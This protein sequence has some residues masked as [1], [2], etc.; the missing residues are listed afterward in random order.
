MG[1]GYLQ[2]K[3]FFTLDI[4]LYMGNGYLHRKNQP[5]RK[6]FFTWEMFIYIRT[7]C[8]PVILKESVS[9][10]I[11]CTNSRCKGIFRIPLSPKDSIIYMGNYYLHRKHI[12]SSH[13]GQWP[14]LLTLAFKKKNTFQSS[15]TMAHS[16]HAGISNSVQS[17]Q[18][19]NISK[20]MVLVHLLRRVICRE[21]F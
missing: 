15:W 21:C 3:S 8:L 17:A 20:V 10:Y 12:P 16:P 9:S 2:R 5:Q 7:I 18:K 13:L 4:F 6:S 11:Y 1:N 14:T 19:T